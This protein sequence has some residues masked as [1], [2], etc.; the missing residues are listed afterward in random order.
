[1]RAVPAALQTQFDSGATTHCRCWRVDRVFGGPLGFTDHDRNLVFGG[2]IFEAEA[3]FEASGVERGLGLAIDNA[4]AS[5]ALRS[6][7]ITN[8]DIE[9]GAYDG[10]EIRQ[11]LV[12]WREPSNRMLVFR[13]EIGEVRRGAV[14]FEVELRGLAE[15]LNRPLGRHFLNNCDAALGDAR[16]KVDVGD[17]AFRG[18]GA[19]AETEDART[20]RVLDIGGFEDGWFDEGVVEWRTGVLAGRKSAVATHRKGGGVRLAMTADMTPA[21]APGDA[22]T[23]IAGCDKR[24]E[25][26]AAKF[27]NTV[28]FR[29]FPFIPG[30]G[31]VAAYPVEGGVYDGGSLG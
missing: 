18:E 6:D 13:G 21:P 30:D 29:G 16:C 23:V 22:F 12:D 7:R 19:V 25:T 2:A 14:A 31:W 11:W 4:S 17:A 15:R 9:S 26:C 28:N 24:Y 3:G 20:V 1:M 27:A 5:G 8:E 10:A